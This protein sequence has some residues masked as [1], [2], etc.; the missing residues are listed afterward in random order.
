[1]PNISAQFQSNVGLSRNIFI[2]ESN[3]KLHGKPSNE[4][5]ADTYGWTNMKQIGVSATVQTRI[6]ITCDNGEERT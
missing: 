6:K 3:Q 4:N 5:R 1:V 2:Q